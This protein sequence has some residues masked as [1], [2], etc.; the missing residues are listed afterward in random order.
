MN[1]TQIQTTLAPLVAFFAGLLAGK[2]VFGLDAT[3]WTTVIG[4]IVAG[5]A[6]IWGAIVTRGSSLIS[7]AANQPE[8]QS[9]KLEPSAS[10]ATV[11]A[12]PRNVT[13]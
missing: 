13:K 6:A 8:V 5:G 12:T 4:A 11:D 3:T 9:I 7:A 10:S 1:P 2:G